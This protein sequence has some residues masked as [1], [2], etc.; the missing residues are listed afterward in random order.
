MPI[1]A[2][3]RA[4]LV[5]VIIAVVTTVL[6]VAFAVGVLVPLA[7][8]PGTVQGAG[9]VT[10]ED[11]TAGEFGDVTVGSGIK[12]VVATGGASSVTLSAQANLLKLIHTDVSDGRLTV[13]VDPPGISSTEQIT[14]TLVV[15][16]LRSLTLGSG[17]TATVETMGGG[18]LSV[19]LSG[20]ATMKAIGNVESL[21]L[22][23]SSGAS[24]KLGELVVVGSAV[25]DLSAG[26]SAELHVTGAITGTAGAGSTLT[27]TARPASVD[28]STTGGATVK[29]G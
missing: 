9:E 25:V 6:A 26:S 16:Q 29:G 8:P 23:A 1:R 4:T 21:A 18:P 13:S 11:R 17:A 10:S 28:V 24:A 2:P 15:R 14:L 12:V 19:D 7:S 20:G 22:T 5:L 3:R 27:L